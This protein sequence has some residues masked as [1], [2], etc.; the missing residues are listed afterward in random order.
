MQ[1]TPIG[2]MRRRLA[3]QAP[4]EVPDL[5]GG[6]ARSWADVATL[7]AAVE[8]LASAPVVLGD[9]PTSRTTHRVT[10]RWRSGVAAGMRLAEGARI[11]SIRT[12]FD[13][14][15]RRRRLVLLVEE[16]GA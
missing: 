15:E 11:F 10:L 12:A 1:P 4:V 5:A 14:D 13:P 2:A 6:V 3:L 9:A 7:W 16:E 8:P